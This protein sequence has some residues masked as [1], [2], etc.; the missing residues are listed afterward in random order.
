M[1][2]KIN[3]ASF[4]LIVVHILTFG[5]RHSF[6]DIPRCIGWGVVCFD[7]LC[8]CFFCFAFVLFMVS[9]F[10]FFISFVFDNHTSLSP[11]VLLLKCCSFQKDPL[12]QC[13]LGGMSS[14]CNES[15]KVTLTMGYY[16]IHPQ[17]ALI[18]SL[19]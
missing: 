16:L 1:F 13:L 17:S 8:C 19:S 4:R 18:C 5:I 7:S 12:R 6:E 10:C 14:I 11:N 9:F 2:E 15:S 3:N